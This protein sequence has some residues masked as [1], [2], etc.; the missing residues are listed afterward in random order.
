LVRFA[1]R[2]LSAETAIRGSGCS[3]RERACP[4]VA[5]PP[6]QRAM[7]QPKAPARKRSFIP[8]NSRASGPPNRRRG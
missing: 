3:A 1:T 7:R 8:W 2:M 6:I 4:M 5:C